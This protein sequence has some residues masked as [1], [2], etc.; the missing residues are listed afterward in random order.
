MRIFL[1]HNHCP[2]E[3]EK[4]PGKPP[5][6]QKTTTNFRQT[7]KNKQNKTTFCVPPCALTPGQNIGVV[8]AVLLLEVGVGGQEGGALR[9]DVRE[10]Q[11]ALR[12]QGRPVLVGAKPLWPS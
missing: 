5:P 8:M 1:N 3:N 4:P 2:A 12:R 11:Q 7:G 10:V 9:D 6:K